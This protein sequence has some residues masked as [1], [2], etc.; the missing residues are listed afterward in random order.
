M[1]GKRTRKL[2]KGGIAVS[3]EVYDSLSEEH[4]AS[5]SFTV[6]DCKPL[7]EIAGATILAKRAGF[8]GVSL[9]PFV[10]EYLQLRDSG[11]IDDSF[12]D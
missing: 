1:K 3:Q 11:Q 10:Y 6:D 8:R 2:A 5:G 4:K 7:Q 9:T 12:F